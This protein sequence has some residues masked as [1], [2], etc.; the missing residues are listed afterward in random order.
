M[1]SVNALIQNLLPKWWIEVLE[2]SGAMEPFLKNTKAKFFHSPNYGKNVNEFKKA[3]S[4]R[5]FSLMF[6]FKSTVE[7]EKYWQMIQQKI[8]NQL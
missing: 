1:G 8:F 6:D 3:I 2:G 7:G 5:Q 4:K